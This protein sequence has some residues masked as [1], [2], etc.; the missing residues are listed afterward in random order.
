MVGQGSQGLPNRQ[1]GYTSV[2]PKNNK[3]K[4][5]K[6]NTYCYFFFCLHNRNENN[7]SHRGNFSTQQ[8]TCDNHRVHQGYGDQRGGYQSSYAPDS[9]YQRQG[10]FREDLRDYYGT[11]PNRQT[12]RGNYIS[13]QNRFAPL[14]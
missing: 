7:Y 1:Q 3:N 13:T 11:H 6:N 5:K 2:K 9:G 10:N 4:H 14:S 12:P 8:T